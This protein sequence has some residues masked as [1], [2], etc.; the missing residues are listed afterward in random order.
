GCW[1]RCGATTRSR[2]RTRS[3]CSSPT[4]D[5]SWKRAVSLGSFIRSA[6]RATSSAY[7]RTP[8]RWRLAGGSAALTFVILCGFAIVVGFLTTRQIRIQFNDSV[9]ESADYVAQHARVAFDPG[10]GQP[11]CGA[12]PEM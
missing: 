3:R 5:G 1:T 11:D 8:T 12:L 7:R 10:T 2:R 6:A 4:C 9:R